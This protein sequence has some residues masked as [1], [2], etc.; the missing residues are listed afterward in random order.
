MKDEVWK[1]GIKTGVGYWNHTRITPVLDRKCSCVLMRRLFSFKTFP[2]CSRTRT[3]QQKS[4]LLVG[5]PT[6]P[7][8]H[9][10]ISP[11]SGTGEGIEGASSDSCEF[12][13]NGKQGGIE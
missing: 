10:G 5:M 9:V 6:M 12:G 8:L 4:P 3:E 2:S 7:P 13:I 11:V 1:S